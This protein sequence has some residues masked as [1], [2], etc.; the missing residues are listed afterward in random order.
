MIVFLNRAFVEA[1]PRIATDDR[2]F[3]LGDGVFETL[4]LESGRAA[5]VDAHVTRL[6]KG[7]AALRIEP[8]TELD[9]LGDILGGLYARNH[10]SGPAAARVTVTRG[11]GARGLSFPPEGEA[12]ST[13]LASVAP[14]AA[15]SGAARLIVSERIRLSTGSATQF[16]PVGGYLENML[17]LD[18]ARRAGADDAVLFNE[19]GRPV[20][21]SASNI[22]LIGDRD[23]LA[24]PSLNEGAMQGVVRGLVVEGAQALGLEISERAVEPAEIEHGRVFLTNSLTGLRPAA[25]VDGEPAEKSDVLSKLQTWYLDR[26][27]AS[28]GANT[29]QGETATT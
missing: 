11:P 15:P 10:A 1:G 5:F 28:L 18:D 9:R 20:C 22:F 27:A 16:K 21:A 14:Y 23:R 7:L 3:L 19:H 13:F 12:R 4:Y 6:R 26:L 8:P 2:G 24:T 25:L 17:A 29:A